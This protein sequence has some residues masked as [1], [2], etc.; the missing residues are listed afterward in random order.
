M[1]NK[2]VIIV[3]DDTEPDDDKKNVEMKPLRN[4]KPYIGGNAANNK[5]DK[6]RNIDDYNSKEELLFVPDD[7][8][9]GYESGVDN[10]NNNNN[11]SVPASSTL[12][13]K[14]TC[15][16]RF[17]DAVDNELGAVY[18]TLLVMCAV[19]SVFLVTHKTDC[20]V[21]SVEVLGGYDTN[22]RPIYALSAIVTRVGASSNYTRC[23]H[24]A[25]FSAGDPQTPKSIK[26]ELDDWGVGT[27]HACAF[28]PYTN[29][30]ELSRFSMSPYFYGANLTFTIYAFVV[31]A[32]YGFRDMRHSY[33]KR[34]N[35]FGPPSY[36]LYA[37]AQCGICKDKFA[38]S[39]E[40]PQGSHYYCKI[41]GKL[42]H[43][44]CIENS[45]SKS[46]KCKCGTSRPLTAFNVPR[47][48]SN[49]ENFVILQ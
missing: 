24:Y 5:E 43:H 48:G 29:H 25:V 46:K 47:K 13:R 9:D 3:I 17:L 32:Y 44:N 10:D 15:L 8:N 27:I 35:E 4:Y 16:K 22:M 18:L 14:P 37:R 31:L 39:E 41:C 36:E 20:E 2:D 26:T 28:N 6:D 45:I 49:V 42:Y 1:A 38:S 40:N 34:H 7:K 33:S 11:N 23:V 12:L 30:L 21:E 19:S